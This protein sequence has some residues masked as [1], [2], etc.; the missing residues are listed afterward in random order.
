MKKR[1]K[2]DQKRKFI[3]KSS[4]KSIE[5]M[6]EFNNII[7]GATS[8][9]ITIDDNIKSERQQAIIIK[10]IEHG[11]NN[12]NNIRFESNNAFD[13][14]ITIDYD[15][16]SER[17]AMIIENIEH[18]N[19]NNNNIGFESNAFDNEITIHDDITSERQAIII[20]N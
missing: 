15:I 7:R 9:K 17:K 13:N 1:T 11:K 18:G 10:N 3:N 14:E 16:T 20:E 2:L 8:N 12:N 6:N 19:N 5:L 4:L